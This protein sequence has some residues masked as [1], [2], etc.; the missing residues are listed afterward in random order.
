[1]ANKLELLNQSG[2]NNSIQIKDGLNKGN[3]LP[4]F[5]LTDFTG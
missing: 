1:M 5:S 2:I 4:S 3:I